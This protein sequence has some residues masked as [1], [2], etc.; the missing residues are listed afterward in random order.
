MQSG[1]VSYFVF[2]QLDKGRKEFSGLTQKQIEDKITKGD[3]YLAA[4]NTYLGRSG[5]I[6]KLD[7]QKVLVKEYLAAEFVK[8]LIGESA[9]YGMVLKHDTMIK[10]ILAK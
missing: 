1:V 3:L 10:S 9:Y 6:F 5:L 2:E 7:K 4:F 8:Q